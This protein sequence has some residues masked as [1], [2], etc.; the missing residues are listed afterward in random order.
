MKLIYAIYII[1]LHAIIGVLAYYLLQEQKLYFF[2]A[3]FGII[4]SL[5]IAYAILRRFEKPLEFI[6]EGQN[7]IAD[8]DFNVKYIPTNSTEMNELISVYNDMIDNIRTERVQAQEQHYFL[9]KIIEKKGIKSK[10]IIHD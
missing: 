6:S 2:L 3:E 4:A 1:I 7:A 10:A 5:I 9:Q 8:K